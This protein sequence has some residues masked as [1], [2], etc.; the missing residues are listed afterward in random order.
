MTGQG[1]QPSGTMNPAGRDTA[2]PRWTA[3]LHGPAYDDI[4]AAAAAATEA[5]TDLIQWSGRDGHVV[6]TAAQ[7]AWRDLWADHTEV[8]HPQ[9][10]PDP[11][12]EPDLEPEI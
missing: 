3:G 5:G 1:R 10:E 2:P 8:I 9:P 6:P 12:P 7:Q 4:A 11:R